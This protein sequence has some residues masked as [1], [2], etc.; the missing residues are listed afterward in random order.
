MLAAGQLGWTVTVARVLTFA[1]GTKTEEKREVTYNPRIRPVEVH[2]SRIP[3]GEE[4][5][6]GEEYPSP[7]DE[8]DEAGEEDRPD[9]EGDPES[10]EERLLLDG[11]ELPPTPAALA[12]EA[13]PPEP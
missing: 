11:A 3:G 1:D 6:T 13:T 8:E 5:Y 2:P 9:E 7:E 12:L 10:E 4:G